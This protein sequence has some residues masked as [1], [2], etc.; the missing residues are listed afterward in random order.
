M[1]NL[2]LRFFDKQG[3]PLNFQYIGPTGSAELDGS[4]SYFA[5]NSGTTP[6]QGYM[7]FVDA[8]AL[9][10]KI[11]INSTDRNGSSVVAWAN[12]VL[13]A[14]VD[15]AK[16]RV[17]LSVYPAQNLSFSVGDISISGTTVE[18]SISKVI[19][20]T[21]IS[22]QNN[23]TMTTV[24]RDLPGGH[25]YGEMYFDPVSAG[26][27]E[28]QQIFIV[29]QFVVSGTEELGYPHTNATGAS[30]SPLW[31]TRWEN[32]TYGNT[33]VSDVIFTYQITQNNPEIGGSPSIVN[34]QNIAIPVEKFP[35]DFYSVE[36]PGY[37]QTTSV[38]STALTINVALNAPDV[39]AEVYERRLIVED[40]TSGVPEKIVE[41]LFYGQIIG[42]DSRL[43]VL[44]ANLGRAFYQSDS[45][46]LRQ[47]NPSEPFPNWVEINE[48]RKELMVAGEEIFPYIG[49]YKGLIGALQFFGYQDLR[50]KEYWLNLAYQKVKV[51]P[52]LENQIFLDK[53]DR[54]FMV[55]QSLQ[56]ADLLDNENSGK[57]R[58]EQTYGPDADG[59]YVLNVSGE[60]TLVPSK[61]YK[62]TSLFGLYYDLNRASPLEDEYGYPIVEE[63]FFFSHEEILTKLFAL[64]Q[65][66]KLTYLPL[67]AR[68]VD[69][70]GEGV[71]FEVYN[72][73]SWTDTMERND[74]DSGFNFDVKSNPPKGFIEDLRAFGLRTSS[75]AIQTPMN[76]FNEFDFT[77]SVIGPS[78]SAF[79]FVGPAGLAVGG[80]NP[81]LTLERGKMYSFG[82]TTSLYNF[83]LTADPS[84]SQV[85]PLGVTNNGAPGAT[86]GNVV[87]RVNP[88]EQ[89]TIYYYSSVNSDL[90]GSINIVNSPASD[91]GNTSLPLSSNQRYNPVQNTDMQIA[92]SNFYYLKENGLIKSLGDGTSDPVQLIDPATGQTYKNPI[93]MP[94]IL[95]TILDEWVWDEMGVS[96]SSLNLPEFKVGD[97]VDIK[98]FQ[99]PNGP[100]YGPSGPTGTTGGGGGQ[101]VDAFYDSQ[102]YEVK[103]SSTLTNTNL[104]VNLLTSVI[105]EMQLLTWANIDFSNYNEVEWI[106]EKSAT[107]PGSPYYF[108]YRGPIMDYYKLAHFLP[109][110]GEYT[111]TCNIY[112]SY[113]FKSNVIKRSLIKVDPV[114]I[115]VDGWTR[116]RENEYYS[117]N[118]TVRDWSSYDSI[119]EYPAEGKTY[120]ELIKQIPPE[121]LE[122]STYG[123]NVQGTQDMLVKTS[124]LPVGASGNI[125]LDQN[126][127]GIAQAYSTKIS[128]NQYNYVTIFTDQDHGFADGS[129]VFIRNSSPQINGAWHITI[130]EGATGNSFEIP[131]FLT[132]I[133]SL[134]FVGGIGSTGGIPTTILYI[135]PTYYPN[136]TVTGG[137]SIDIRVNGR[138]IGATSAGES[139]QSTV[140]SIVEVVNA[141]YT[142][143]DYIAGVTGPDSIPSVINI[144]ANT[145]SGNIGN[146]DLL[147]A[148]VTGSL[149]IVSI[150]SA[151]SGGDSES[152]GYIS[153][154]QNYGS[155]PDENLRY[156]G[157]L[158]LDWD[159]LPTSTWDEA[160]AHGW[161]DF[162]YDNGWLGGFEIH[163]SKVGD[164][165]KVSTGNETYP[166][167][168]GVTFSATGG[169]TGPTGYI[170]LSGAADELNSS[171]EPHISNF[172]YQVIPYGSGDLL[173]TTGPL[174][175]S[176]VTAGATSGPF[177]SPPTVPGAAPQ[178]IVSFT[179]ATGP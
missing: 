93:G 132:N 100:F 175:P 35:T 152:N 141:V 111:V 30:G 8:D 162:E 80:F 144:L 10:P 3:D 9:N 137:G 121:I 170:T 39:A 2:H 106:L 70:T 116:Y 167:P 155:F 101:I 14:I 32:D 40:I 134:E 16:I 25:F 174:D 120:D 37:L 98:T 34:Y 145:V 31:R 148:V 178:L 94:I 114:E 49:A 33:D 6:T 143:P 11:Y 62:K 151:L 61:T 176:F 83:Y 4:F 172:H 7:S 22:N 133:G 13:A 169:I 118:Q 63:A 44:T 138:S 96:W 18:L 130:P 91:L 109:Y 73:R 85:D 153:W 105:Q 67:N 87:I 164:N 126:L 46:I 45:T 57:Y 71:Y 79:S 165:I 140:N 75:D 66:L 50:I 29:Q 51:S 92:I 58:L 142:Q 108:Q 5:I 103:L 21:I 48:K 41:I 54:S 161:Y 158:T 104:T 136:Q 26:L 119:W 159:A 86:G 72:T 156:W 177:P 24:Y 82:L 163:S 1:A 65:R 12:S 38:N 147:T 81:T 117:W 64:K 56:I 28:N 15:G 131:V 95:E 76:Y 52:L 97:L 89:N 149:E 107:Q 90:R 60:G 127:Y 110:V 129:L 150:D 157:Y 23:I 20:S 102:T 125:V 122:F 84:Y 53:Y 19:G 128:G 42:E 173:T 55:N 36:Y 59:N 77:V 68:I 166:F 115:D 123:N 27:Y 113:N 17:D 135:V 124:N 168:V 139:L 74:I 154:N 88:Q 78:G 99:D 179:Y 171:T 146:G 112:D 69:I 160:Y 43:D 47:H